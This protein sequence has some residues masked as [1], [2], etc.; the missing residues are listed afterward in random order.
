ML[1][2]NILNSH[3][4][5]PGAILFRLLVPCLVPSCVQGKHGL[6]LSA[7]TEPTKQHQHMLPQN[8]DL[9]P[10]NRFGFPVGVPFQAT[11]TNPQR[12]THR[13]TRTQTHTH[14]QPCFLESGTLEQAPSP[15]RFPR[16]PQGQKGTR[17]GAIWMEQILPG[18][19]SW[20][21][22][23]GVLRGFRP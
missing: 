7:A 9:D 13:H 3:S 11:P 17:G 6:K 14:T 4:Q 21:S 23:P 19:V 5:V 12:G 22:A 20:V 2:P 15:T 1:N 10:T 18:L 8:R 16:S